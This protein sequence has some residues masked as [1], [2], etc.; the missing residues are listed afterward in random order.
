M[1]EQYYSTA[2]DSEGAMAA[3]LQY[4][5]LLYGNFV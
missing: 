5:L 4:C 3:V 1:S 2:W